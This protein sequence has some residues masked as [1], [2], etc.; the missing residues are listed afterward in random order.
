MDPAHAISKDFSGGCSCGRIKFIVFG[1]PVLVAACH[2]A[3]CRRHTGAPVAVYADVRVT[4][5][6]PLGEP[7]DWFE[8]SPGA[9]RGFCIRC[10]STLAFK[11]E[12]SPAMINLHIGAFDLPALLPPTRNE[13][14]SARLPWLESVA[15]DG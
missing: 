2:C 8:T 12:N 5:F 7:I 15:R 6:R 1:A 11:G 10:G 14:T 4:A 9:F 3:D 13:C